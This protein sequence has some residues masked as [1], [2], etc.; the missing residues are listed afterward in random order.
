MASP[1]DERHSTILSMEDKLQKWKF[2][3]IIVNTIWDPESS[4]HSDYNLL[5]Y[6]AVHLLPCNPVILSRM[7]S[8]FDRVY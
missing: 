5:R 3:H 2:P 1:Q 4:E 7:E 6:N 8:G